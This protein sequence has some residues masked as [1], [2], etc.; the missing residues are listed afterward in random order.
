MFQLVS[1][2]LIGLTFM[3]WS[4]DGW[5]NLLIKIIYGGVMLWG[6]FETAKQFGYIVKI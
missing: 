6:V 4:K 2:A 1:T 5:Y 3:I